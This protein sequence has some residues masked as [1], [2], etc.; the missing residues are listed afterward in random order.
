[1]MKEVM[2]AM[3]S[4]VVIHRSSVG[5]TVFESEEMRDQKREKDFFERKKAIKEMK[6][7]LEDLAPRPDAGSF[8]ARMEKRAQKGHYCRYD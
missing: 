8:Q 4:S 7:D 1:M 6:E 2:H 3:K 5:M